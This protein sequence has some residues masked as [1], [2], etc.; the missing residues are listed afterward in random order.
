[1]WLP[2]KPE[3]NGIPQVMNCPGFPNDTAEEAKKVAEAICEDF[4]EEET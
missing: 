2:G 3:L 4:N 1:M